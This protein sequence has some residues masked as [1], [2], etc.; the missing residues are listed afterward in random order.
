MSKE[1]ETT[2]KVVMNNQNQLEIFYF[3]VVSLF[4]LMLTWHTDSQENETMA[5]HVKKVAHPCFI[6]TA[7]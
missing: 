6:D 2:T 7:S 3:D 1:E 4:N 5:L